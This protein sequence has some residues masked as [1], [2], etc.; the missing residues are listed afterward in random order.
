MRHSWKSQGYETGISWSWKLYFHKRL[1][2]KYIKLWTNKYIHNFW[3]SNGSTKI[4]WR[5]NS[6]PNAISHHTSLENLLPDNELFKDGKFESNQL[7]FVLAVL[8]KY[9]F[10]IAVLYLLLAVYLLIFNLFLNILYCFVSVIV[11]I[12][13]QKTF[14]ETKT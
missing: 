7:L 4:K 14:R 10:L 6:K 1:W 13:V 2:S 8:F 12:N 5:E 3:V 9:L 11:V